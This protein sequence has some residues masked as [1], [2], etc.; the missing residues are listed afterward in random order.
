M[1]LTSIWE[2][3]FLRELSKIFVFFLFGFY[4]LYVLIDYSTHSS[5][6]KKYHI[7]FTDIA[8]YYGFEFVTRMEIL[9]PFAILIACIKILCSLNRN[10]ELIALMASGIKLKRLMLPFAA[11]GLFFTGIIYFNSEVL[12]P[13][14]LKY[15]QHFEQTRTKEK[16]K[17]HHNPFI[18]QLTLEDGSSLVFQAYDIQSESFFDAYWIRS[19]DDIYRIRTLYPYAPI[20][21]GITVEHFMRNS[22]GGLV[23]VEILE[24]KLFPE[25][26]FN[27]T[28]LLD[29]V[30][31]PANQSL[32]ALK[33]KLPSH[34]DILSE[35]EARLLTTFYYKLALPWLCFLAAIAPIPFCTRFSRTLPIFF[36]Y[37]FSLFGLV[38]FYLVMD[39]SAILGE[40]Q[41]L[42]PEIAIW[43]PFAIFASFFGWRYAKL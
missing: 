42:S 9:V 6:F 36:I 8:T 29:T 30:I 22:Q 14:A 43:M 2:R 24:E 16:Q 31:S 38:A 25:M 41:F 11:F 19:I 7:S 10:N 33:E 15:H 27:K 17:K 13:M 26:H 4:G 28:T 40:R 18:Q 3:Y 39:A 23:I 37:A 34:R 35:K 12:Q 20:P 5:N 32:A 21:K 1:L